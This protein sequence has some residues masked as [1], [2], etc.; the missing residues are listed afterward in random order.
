MGKKIANNIVLVFGVLFL[1]GGFWLAYE[2]GIPLLLEAEGLIHNLKCGE[3]LACA[4]RDMNFNIIINDNPVTL[5]G[6][7]AFFT[8]YAFVI[9][10]QIKY[11]FTATTSNQDIIQ[12]IVFLIV[13]SET[14]LNDVKSLTYEEIK[15]RFENRGLIELIKQPDGTYHKDGNWAFPNK[16]TV[17]VVPFIVDNNGKTTQLQETDVLFEIVEQSVKSRAI[18][19]H[20]EKIGNKTI[21]ALTWIGIALAPILLGMDF[22]VRVVLRD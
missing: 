9:Y 17:L 4:S 16:S 13:T 20:D 15:Q 10:S 8:D 2:K 22:I 3:G 21:L 7:F 12:K 1:L 6:N 19:Q 5:K 11:D 18:D 14:N